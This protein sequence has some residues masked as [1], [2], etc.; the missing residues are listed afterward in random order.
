MVAAAA[1]TVCATSRPVELQAGGF[2]VLLGA[3]VSV[4][5]AYGVT[6]PLL[7]SLIARLIGSADVGEVARH[8]GWL[9]GVYTVAMF[10]LAPAWGALSD[11]IDRRLVMLV[12]LVGS[13]GTLAA[14]DFITG[15]AGLYAMRIASGAL[16]AAVLPAVLASVVDLSA[17]S[18]RGKRFAAVSSATASGFL[19]G[20]AV[21]SILSAMVASPPADMRLGG[22]LMPDSPF[23]MV[24]FVSLLAAAAVMAAPR[25]TGRRLEATPDVQ[26]SEYPPAIWHALWLTAIVVF[27]M[28]VAEV[29]ITL[30][31]TQALSLDPRVISAYFALCS[32]VMITVQAW[33]YPWLQQRLG[34]R[35]LQASAFLGM[36]LGLA[37]LPHTKALWLLGMAVAL[38]AAGIGILIPALAARISGAAGSRQGRALGQQ[39]AAANVGQAVAAFATGFLYATAVPFPFLLAAAVLALGAWLVGRAPSWTRS[40]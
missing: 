37:I 28:T 3:A 34:E 18:D 7:P 19:I 22:L 36:A 2:A 39:T 25:S 31:G 27:G 23:M 20:P 30:L 32:V 5:M 21:G 26:A 4:S 40:R 29:G 16:S 33:A 11:R 10:T 13:A 35:E 17:P 9:T 12:G 38:S 14:L 8:T 1:E 6:L 24:A 15:L